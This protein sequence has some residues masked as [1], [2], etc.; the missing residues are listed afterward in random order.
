MFPVRTITRRRA[1]MSMPERKID[2]NPYQKLNENTVM[3]NLQPLQSCKLNKNLRNYAVSL[4]EF[5]SNHSANLE[6]K[7]AKT[8]ADDVVPGIMDLDAFKEAVSRF[9]YDMLDENVSIIDESIKEMK[10]SDR[11][12]KNNEI[13]N[14]RFNVSKFISECTNDKKCVEELC[15]MI[16]T[17]NIPI[18]AKYN[19][20]LENILYSMKTNARAITESEILECVTGYYMVRE[21]PLTDPEYAKMKHVLEMSEIYDQDTI[22]SVTIT[23]TMSSNYSLNKK[24][25]TVLANRATCKEVEDAILSVARVNTEKDASKSIELIGDIVTYSFINDDDRALLYGALNLMPIV[26][27]IPEEFFNLEVSKYVNVPGSKYGLITPTIIDDDDE[28][29]QTV[30]DVK[31]MTNEQLTNYSFC[32]AVNDNEDVKK[33]IEQFKAEQNKTEP[34]LRRLVTKFY[35]KKPEDVIDE[36]PSFLSIIR[37]AF[38][39]ALTTIPYI[40]PALALISALVNWFIR[41]R[42]SQKESEK[43]LKY[44]K[45]EKSK[46]K[47]KIENT[48]GEEKKRF[49]QYNA[50]LEKSIKKVSAYLESI[51]GEYRTDDDGDDDFDWDMSLDESIA[52]IGD[53]T[54]MANNQAMLE[55]S[56]LGDSDFDSVL[57]MVIGNEYIDN[58][59]MSRVGRFDKESLEQVANMLVENDVEMF[60]EF[61]DVMSKSSLSESADEIL[62]NLYYDNYHKNYMI[63]TEAST[64]WQRLNSDP[65]L[66]NPIENLV[67]THVYNEA[68]QQIVQEKFNLNSVKLVL[69]DAKRKAQ[70]LNTKI[71]SAVQ[72]ANAYGNNVIS[73]IEKSMTSDR[74][75]ALIKG[76]ILP[77]FTQMIKYAIV[78][79]GAGI[80]FQPAAAVITAVGIFATNKALTYREKKMLLDEIETEL[81]VVEKQIS[82]AENDQDMKQYR[83]LLNMQKKLIR[84]RQRI[85]Y[86]MKPV[87]KNVPIPSA[88]TG[89]RD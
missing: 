36:L 2:I 62:Q 19:I 29:L 33:L 24:K 69:Q 84:E 21:K 46:V 25:L 45:D 76:R 3:A 77:S 54:Q 55:L 57:K 23:E 12:L 8:I 75:E 67:R 16:D 87:G 61:M 70:S 34:L 47:D 52:F 17:Y 53:I 59:Y 68:V 89:K 65:E 80:I 22:H 4:L 40:G 74:R 35:T 79:A 18:H 7:V 10:I 63:T 26:S 51:D 64:L 71:K 13:L 50:E 82:I 31:N 49:E 6:T 20:A 88:T 37:V 28:M 60:R 81:K 85:K 38:I 72:T 48:S 1:R 11:V 32:E 66:T 86:N 58:F 30:F 14:K 9:S 44:L 41:K 78:I 42:L 43:L 39:A 56:L 27:G 5:A 73:G 15:A 83:I